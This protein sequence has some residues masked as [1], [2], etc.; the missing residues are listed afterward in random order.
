MKA[1]RLVRITWQLTAEEEEC[2][3]RHLRERW[4]V[5]MDPVLSRMFGWTPSAE[6]TESK[7]AGADKAERFVA[8]AEP[9]KDEEDARAKEARKLRQRWSS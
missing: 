6:S 5:T 2:I 8:L 7:K 4:E 9:E 1:R 3:L